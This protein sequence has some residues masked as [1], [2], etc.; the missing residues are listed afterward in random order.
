M[1]R[2]NTDL[3]SIDWQRMKWTLIK[4]VSADIF[5]LKIVLTRYYSSKTGYPICMDSN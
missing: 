3:D 5:D 2:T 1:V 4:Q